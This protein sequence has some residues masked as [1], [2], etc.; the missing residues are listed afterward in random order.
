MRTIVKWPGI[1]LGILV[2]LGTLA[3]VAFYAVTQY[4][5]DRT[6]SAPQIA[7]AV[8]RDAQSIAA[9][10]HIAATRGCNGCHDD[11]LQGRVFHGRWGLVLVV[12]PNITQVIRHYSDPQLERLLRYGVQPDGRSVFIMPSSTFYNLS[13]RDIVN[14]IAYLRS[15]PPVENFLPASHFDILGRWQ[16]L[17]GAWLPEAARIARLGPRIVEGDPAPT[18]AYGDYL[19][20]STCTECHGT[21][22]HGGKAV[23]AP[24]L[25]IAKAYSSQNFA[26]LM[27]TGI[28]NGNR[29]LGLMS[30]VAKARFSH[31]NAT[32]VTAIYTY[33]QSRSISQ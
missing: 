16:L 17:T 32:E 23:G 6:Y 28:G 2:L 33:L 12:T 1:V 7:L 11:H 21:N 9:G 30:E 8:P 4:Q 29:E 31:F 25:I 22:L 14:L 13:D 15:V 24:D 5:L 18:A 27:S 3:A 26:R 19:V 20:H 10:E